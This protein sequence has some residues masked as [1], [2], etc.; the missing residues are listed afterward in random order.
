MNKSINPSIHPFINESIHPSSLL[1]HHSRP[2]PIDL[3]FD[4]AV[5]D[6]L[7]LQVRETLR[8]ALSA[9]AASC[10]RAAFPTHHCGVQT[11]ACCTVI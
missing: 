11:G 5:F 4:P 1:K 7:R 9:L 10:W 3:V 8:A 6:V 2:H